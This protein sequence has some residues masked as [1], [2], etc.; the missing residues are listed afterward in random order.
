VGT[1]QLLWI[2]PFGFSR[3][4][5]REGGIRVHSMS[6]HLA[7]PANSRCK[8]I[9]WTRSS[10]PRLRDGCKWHEAESTGSVSNRCRGMQMWV[11]RCSDASSV[12][13]LGWP[14][15]CGNRGHGAVAVQ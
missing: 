2:Q 13:C 5:N 3:S 12:Q 14:W 9:E 10:Q 1:S 15:V 8:D 4:R 7:S 6:L 11:Y